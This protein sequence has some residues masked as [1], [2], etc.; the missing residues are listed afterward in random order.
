MVTRATW[1]EQLT[2]EARTVVRGLRRDVWFTLGIIVTVATALAANAAL[3]AF[4][5]GYFW[6]PLPIARAADHVE[7]AGRDGVGR[8][9]SAWGSAQAWRIKQGATAVLDGV[10]AVAERRAAV[11]PPGGNEP[12]PAMGAVVTREYF[13]LVEPRLALGRLPFS[14]SR[15]G[16]DAAGIVLSDAGW[17]RLA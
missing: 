1:L 7:I 15:G 4:L 2:G 12:Q 16:N 14:P 6:K 9:N 10:Y 17:R 8:V 11:V 3:V 5:N 13:A